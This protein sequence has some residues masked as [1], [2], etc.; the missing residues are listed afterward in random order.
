MSWQYAS[1]TFLWSSCIFHHL[2]LDIKEKK[3]MSD[4]EM[5]V[6]TVFVDFN[7]A[8]GTCVSCWS[9]RSGSITHWPFI[10]SD[11]DSTAVFKYLSDLNRVDES[12]NNNVSRMSLNSCTKNKKH[13]PGIHGITEYMTSIQE[14]PG[15]N[16]LSI[17]G[18]R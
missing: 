18:L 13:S 3:E 9:I 7:M 10:V 12:W 8:E 11:R 17:S 4:V 14:K 16:S 2:C 15:R 6:Y 1:S 5:H